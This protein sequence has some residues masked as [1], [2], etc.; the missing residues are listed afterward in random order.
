MGCYVPKMGTNAVDRGPASERVAENVKRLRRLR[1]LS[2]NDLSERM[3]QL[4][5]PMQ[6]SGLSKI[7]QGDR[8][9]DVDDLLALALAL[10]VNANTLLMPADGGP[11]NVDVVPTVAA[12]WRGIWRWATGES[13]LLHWTETGEMA[14]GTARSPKGVY[15]LSRL[16]QWVELTTP[17]RTE[18]ERFAISQALT[19][20]RMDKRE[21]R[22]EEVKQARKRGD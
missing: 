3:G 7:E 16:V 8:R 2:L 10:E 20:L 18:E 11:P 1:G 4:G 13:P 6:A 22:V 21:D 12:Q 9:V 14:P 15:D 17:H 19:K 5:R